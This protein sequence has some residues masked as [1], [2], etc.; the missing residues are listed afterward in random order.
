MKKLVTS[1]S[2]MVMSLLGFMGDAQS[3]A[4]GMQIIRNADASQ[5]GKLAPGFYIIGGKKPYIC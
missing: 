4:Q 3:D 1:I 2:L 5:I